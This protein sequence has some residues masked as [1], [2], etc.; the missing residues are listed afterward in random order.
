MK[1]EEKSTKI[2]TVVVC[3]A[4]ATGKSRLAVDIAREFGGEVIN[5]DSMQIYRGMEIASAMPTEKEKMGIP[6]HLFGIIEPEKS[7]SVAD[8]LILARG[9]IAEV[10]KRGSVSII[11]GGT[12]LYISS[13]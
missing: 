10:S 4:T 2:K 11:V 13:L 12:G 5:A 7:F 1:N 9:K 6:H 8:W 3:G